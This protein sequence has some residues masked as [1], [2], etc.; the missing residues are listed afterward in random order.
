M[1]ELGFDEEALDGLADAGSDSEEEIINE[2]QLASSVS[3]DGKNTPTWLQLFINRAD[4]AN[5]VQAWLTLKNSEHLERGGLRAAIVDA[6]S[7]CS[8]VAEDA[9]TGWRYTSSILRAMDAASA[10]SP[11]ELCATDGRSTCP[12]SGTTGK[13]SDR[14]EKMAAVAV[15]SEQLAPELLAAWRDELRRAPDAASRSHT[16]AAPHWIPMET[17][18][19]TSL[20]DRTIRHVLRLSTSLDGNSL[21]GI[22][23]SIASQA[24]GAEFWTQRVR[25]DAPCKLHWDCDEML[26]QTDEELVC[27]L[28]SAIVYIS[29]EGGPTLMLGRSPT[30]SLGDHTAWL[31]RA[32][33][34]WPHAG[35]IAAFPGDMLHGV[36]PSVSPAATTTPLP[37]QGPTSALRQTVLIN[38][39]AKR[40]QQLSEMPDSLAPRVAPPEESAAEKA[41]RGAEEVAATPGVLR[42]A[43]SSGSVRT[44]IW[45]PAASEEWTAS[46]LSLRMFYGWYT[47]WVQLPEI[48]YRANQ[49][50]ASEVKMWGDGFKT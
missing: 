37:P 35:Q 43:P 26:G 20:L 48:A 29:D 22:A 33:L 30:D 12:K 23:K 41:S 3:E 40:P 9:A 14:V 50:E 47:W 36:M 17:V 46:E 31:E 16:W 34:V 4:A 1:D 15:S 2:M 7:T 49:V 10:L 18:G 44:K 39:W 19:E 38:L 6:R 45:L 8:S 11:S 42:A 32:W 21:D 28:M 27:P 5:V 25:Q 13:W 24:V